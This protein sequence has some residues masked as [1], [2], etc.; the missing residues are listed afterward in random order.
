MKK[1]VCT[2]TN[3][4]NYDQRMIRIAGTLQ[5][6]GYAVMLIGRELP[7]S[8]PLVSRSYKQKRLK[9]YFHRGKLFYLEYNLRLFL[10]LLR[11]KF[12]ILHAVDLDTL[13]PGR[14]I[15]LLKNKTLVFD[16]HEIFTEVPE[17]KDRPLTRKAWHIL[18]QRIVPK[19]KHTMTV[20][21]EVAKW[22]KHQYEIDMLVLR[23]MPYRMLNEDFSEPFYP[24]YFIYQGALNKGRGIE[25]MILAMKNVP[26]ELWLAG[27]GDLSQE[28][29]ALVKKE[30]LEK[31]VRFLGFVLPDDLKKITKE[32]WAGLNVSENICTSYYLSLNNKCFDYLQAGIPAIANP[33]PEYI[34]LNK[35]TETMIF[36]EANPD[37]IRSA[38]LELLNHPEKR[39]HLAQNARIAAQKY[40]WDN[41]QLKLI[42]F[43]EAL[44]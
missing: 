28:L 24:P 33:F 12:D 41:E 6:N 27:E 17:L 38:Y 44:P 30:N 8:K 20:G 10:Y 26:A 36:A 40:H 43:Y 7:A 35:D 9:C 16:A 18:E 1:V 32:A 37:S 39:Q 21:Y 5:Q 19:L 25:A 3:D 13:L 23:N 29:R 4:L 34:A 14:M 15:T 11:Q 42:K 2:V 22:F 31:Q